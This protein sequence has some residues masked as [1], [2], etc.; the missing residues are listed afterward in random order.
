MSSIPLAPTSAQAIDYTRQ[1]Q[2]WHDESDAH[3]EE[4]VAYEL[5][6]LAPYR[7]SDQDTPT[8]DIGC[9]MGFVVASYQRAGLRDVEGIDADAGQIAKAQRRGLPVE[10]VKVEQT[11]TWMNAR[12]GRY[13]FISAI[14]VL[15]HVPVDQQLA[16]LSGVHGMLRPGGMFLCR[17]PNANA[18]LA[19]RFRYID[20]T[21]VCSFTEHSLDFALYNAG[22]RDLQVTE[23]DP[24]RFQLRYFYS[25]MQVLRWFFRGWRRL[26]M[27]AEFGR[28]E[29]ARIPLTLNILGL[30]RK[31][32]G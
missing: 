3:F 11:L 18:A 2:W 30:A 13:G 6:W 29:G 15:E 28:A 31:H 17:V 21:H 10:R 4:M 9:G 25:P 27:M 20:W 12:R 8:L 24:L 1:Y 7:P 23:A 19:S 14:D 22:F 5:N 16:F 32:A 26:E